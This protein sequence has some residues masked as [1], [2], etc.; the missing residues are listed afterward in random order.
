[1]VKTWSK[2]LRDSHLLIGEVLLR[3]KVE[4]ATS[5]TAK[6]FAMKGADKTVELIGSK[7]N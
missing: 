3:T 7:T 4:N 2:D 6:K 5:E 1:M